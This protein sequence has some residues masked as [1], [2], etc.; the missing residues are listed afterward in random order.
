[1]R[2]PGP[3]KRLGR[4]WDRRRSRRKSP[5]SAG[6]GRLGEWLPSDDVQHAI[7][8]TS[9]AYGS[10]RKRVEKLRGSSRGEEV[11]GSMRIGAGR[12]LGG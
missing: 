12:G 3:G 1:M 11:L 8:D 2:G 4:A 5:P 6:V 7:V 9:V 10:A